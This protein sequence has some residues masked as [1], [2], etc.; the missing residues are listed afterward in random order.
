MFFYL[1]YYYT[2]L[3]DVHLKYYQF[4]HKFDMYTGIQKRQRQKTA[5]PDRGRKRQYKVFHF[6]H[7]FLDKGKQT[8]SGKIAYTKKNPGALEGLETC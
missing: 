2:H 4:A 8:E 3:N 6:Q 7:I 5:H 1:G